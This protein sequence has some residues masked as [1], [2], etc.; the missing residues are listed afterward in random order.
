MKINSD[1][2][3][4]EYRNGIYY[5]FIPKSKKNLKEEIVELDKEEI[6]E[7][8]DPKYKIEGYYS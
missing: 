2:C 5:L 4:I 1:D 8:I 7:D 3:Y 6:S